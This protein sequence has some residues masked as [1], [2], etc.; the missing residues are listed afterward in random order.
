MNLR[1][2]LNV[3][4]GFVAVAVLVGMPVTGLVFADQFRVI[5]GST[6][7]LVLT[8]QPQVGLATVL[9]AAGTVTANCITANVLITNINAAATTLNALSNVTAGQII[10]IVGNTSTTVNPTVVVDSGNFK[11]AGD[12]T[13]SADDTL[14]LYAVSSSLF[15]ELTRANN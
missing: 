7:K 14:T 3:L 15:V 4:F 12:F 8:T 6:G 11:L 5:N 9:L 13:A 2:I 10:T 1:K